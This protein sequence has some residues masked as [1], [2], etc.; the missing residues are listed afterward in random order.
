MLN[1]RRPVKDRIATTIHDS[2]CSP[3]PPS[4]PSDDHGC[5]PLLFKQFAWQ[6]RGAL[7][8]NSHGSNFPRV[9]HTNNL[10]RPHKH[11]VE[12]TVARY[13]LH[14]HPLWNSV[15]VSSSQQAL[16]KLRLEMVQERSVPQDV[17]KFFELLVAWFLIAFCRPNLLQH[18]NT[19]RIL[20]SRLVKNRLKVHLCQLWGCIRE[21]WLLF[22]SHILCRFGG[23]IQFGLF[24]LIV[25]LRCI[26]FRQQKS[27]GHG[28]YLHGQL[29]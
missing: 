22:I 6:A 2:W 12:R 19:S 13:Q 25:F 23:G 3:H 21:C 1:G 17:P 29:T 10:R 27:D 16:E 8:F 24:I 11:D 28:C 4:H 18:S 14:D 7:H 9:A 15:N 20:A 5:C 26:P